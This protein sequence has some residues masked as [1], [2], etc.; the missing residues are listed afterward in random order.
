MGK[1]SVDFPFFFAGAT[2]GGQ[3]GGAIG[4]LV[5]A[6]TLIGV[7]FGVLAGSIIGSGAGAFAVPTMIEKG[8]TLYQGYLEKGGEGSF[9]DFIKAGAETLQAGVDSGIEGAMFGILSKLIPVLNQYS[10]FPLG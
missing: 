9:G 6:P 5:S 4:T 8:L 10:P 1:Y 7:P 3:V 2:A